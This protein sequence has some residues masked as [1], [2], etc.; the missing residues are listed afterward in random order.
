[1]KAVA[2][3]EEQFE[4]EKSLTPVNGTVPALRITFLKAFP[5]ILIVWGLAW[6]EYTMWLERSGDLA[7]HSNNTVTLMLVFLPT[8]GSGGGNGVL[9]KYR[10]VRRQIQGE[11]PT[12]RPPDRGF[13]G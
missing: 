11:I 1:L 12:E 13:E 8:F 10:R 3:F 5:G 7:V 6:V 4:S 9:M 2:T